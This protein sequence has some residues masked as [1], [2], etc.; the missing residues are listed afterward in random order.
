MSLLFYWFCY[1]VVVILRDFD[2]SASL[3]TGPHLTLAAEYYQYDR[4]E[5]TTEAIFGFS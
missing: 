5:L 2:I 3:P 4:V 1:Q